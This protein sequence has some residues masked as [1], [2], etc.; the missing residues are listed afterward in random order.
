[1]KS[2]YKTI[3]IPRGYRGIK[4]EAPGVT[5]FIETNTD[6]KTLVDATCH[7]ARFAGDE[8]VVE[9]ADANDRGTF[10]RCGHP[11]EVV[12]LKKSRKKS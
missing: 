5:I 6:G 1:M 7:G 11:A 8:W 2:H 4:V 10:L 12:V 9:A 3:S